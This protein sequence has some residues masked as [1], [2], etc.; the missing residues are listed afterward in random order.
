M[1]VVVGFFIAQW[2]YF[3]PAHSGTDQNGYLVGGRLFAEYLSMEY[4]PVL[5]GARNEFDPHQFVGRMWVGAE[6]STTRERYFPKYPLGYPFLVA[7]AL[8]ASPEALG[9]VVAYWINPVA[10]TLSLWATYLLVRWF[11]G[12]L[13]ALCGL[14]VF[15]SSPVTFGLATNPNSHATAVCCASWGMYLL[16]RWWELRA[17]A[18]RAI[19]AG[20]LLG[21]AATIRYTEATLLLPLL[22][23]IGFNFRSRDKQSWKESALALVGWAIP[24]AL[25]IAYN[26]AAMGKLTG[27]DSTNESIGFS[28]GYAAENWETMLRQFGSTALFFIFPFSVL[29]LLWMLWRETRRAVVLAAWILPCMFVYTF[30]YWAP[31]QQTGQALYIG[32]MRFF[33]TIMPALVACAFW[34]FA[35]MIRVAEETDHPGAAHLAT[36]TMGVA[37]CLSVA[38]HLQNSTFAA[39][40]DQNRRLL[41]KLNA[42]EV[43]AA[44]PARSVIV[45]P[46]AQLLHHLQ[47]M[48]DYSL[49]SGETFNRNFVQGLPNMN[50]DEPQGWEPGRRES[51]FKR[52]K[53]LSQER[54]DDQARRMM[55]AALGA[56]LRVF[57]VAQGR[58]ND[59]TVRRSRRN[60]D[61]TG[62]NVHVADIVK[63]FAVPERFETEVVTGWNVS[64]VRPFAPDAATRPRGR[65]ADMRGLDR[66]NTYWQIVEVTA[67]EKPV[68]RPATRPASK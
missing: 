40:E 27:Y 31:D 14:V 28:I 59:P 58:E 3:V 53:D 62:R 23:V 46:D 41:L 66:R 42:D 6:L 52:L 11:S 34:L 65:R 47:F 44:A 48:R 7:I 38:V 64:I 32:Y 26:L 17:S 22:I 63:R 24:V 30:Y 25:L 16:V 50:P 54:L 29:G 4:R 67:R 13:P 56:N 8:W 2:C 37:T 10:M 43:L 68:A 49:Y 45:A 9:P 21:Y 18:W 19:C 36:L 55:S 57:F 5:P 39:E 61:L 12:A 20:L 1:L 33:L 60:A 51:L 15:A 35:R